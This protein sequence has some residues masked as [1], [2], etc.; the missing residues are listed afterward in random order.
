MSDYN[1]GV[2]YLPAVRNE[3]YAIREKGTEKIIVTLQE[4]ISLALVIF[5]KDTR[6]LMIM[7]GDSKQAL[8][9]TILSIVHVFLGRMKR[10]L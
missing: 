10:K 2:C 4:I 6:R 3:R 1:L 5:E 9:S 7:I 8:V